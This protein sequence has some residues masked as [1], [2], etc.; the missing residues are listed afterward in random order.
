M[1]PTFC[2]PTS[3]RTFNGYANKPPDSDDILLLDDNVRAF[4]LK[5][6]EEFKTVEQI[7]GRSVQSLSSKWREPSLSIHSVHD[8]GP[9][10]E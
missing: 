5:E 3:V 1:V 9:G 10:S 8:S 4:S 7:T 6:Q 2:Y